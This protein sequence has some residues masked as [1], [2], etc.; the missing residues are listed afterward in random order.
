MEMRVRIPP[1]G[2]SL[3]AAVSPTLVAPALFKSTANAA[4]D[5]IVSGAPD[6]G[7]SPVGS[8][9][10]GACSLNGKAGNVFCNHLVAVDDTV[11]HAGGCRWDYIGRG[12]KAKRFES[13]PEQSG[14]SHQT[15]A[16]STEQSTSANAGWTTW[17]RAPARKREVGGSSPPPDCRS[18]S[19][20]S[21][22]PNTCRRH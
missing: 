6:A 13:A 15:L 10:L 2:C 5:Y 19:A 21:V 20:K 17:V 14:M 12:R 4:K 18:S 16:A 3:R 22:S 8:I 7:S 1:C 9:S 11:K